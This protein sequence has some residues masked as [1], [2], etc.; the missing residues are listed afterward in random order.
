MVS[1]YQMEVIYMIRSLWT[2]GTGMNAQQLNIDVISNNLA[3]VNTSGYKKSRVDFQDLV[4]QDLRSSGTPVLT[5]AQIPV[6]SQVGHGVR[7]VATQKMFSQGA[8]EETGNPLDLA[9]E[10]EGFFQILMPDGLVAY[11][12]DGSF[13]RDGD[14][15]LVTSDGFLL[16]P[17]IAIDDDAL[18]ISIGADGTVFVEVADSPV[19]IDIGQIFLVR[20]SNPAGLRNLGRN[21]YAETAA[22]GEPIPGTPGMFGVGTLAQGFLERSNVQVVEEMVN[23]IIAQRAY[24]VCS[25]AIRASDEMLETANN[26]RR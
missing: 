12:R 19:P 26:I 17:P 9:V 8:F 11:T 14:G 24:E 18:A 16:E 5:G 13:K 10:G 2:A 22:S 15:N 25:K 7:P 21:L 20:F 4:Y 23:M 6:G 3:N 1:G